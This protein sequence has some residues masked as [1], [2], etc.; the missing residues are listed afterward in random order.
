MKGMSNE[1]EDQ[2]LQ[3]WNNLCDTKFKAVYSSGVAKRTAHLGTL[4]SMFLALGT[5]GTVASWPLWQAYPIYWAVVLGVIQILQIIKPYIPY[6]GTEKQYLDTSY[7]FERLFLDFELLWKQFERGA[8]Q[9]DET[10][11]RF[12]QLRERG[13]DIESEYSLIIPEWNRL[14]ERANQKK[15]SF[16]HLNYPSI[17]ALTDGCLSESIEDPASA[18]LVKE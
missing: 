5:A 2:R 7:K 9:R 4:Y 10:E 15:E 18:K 12:K 16:M 13:L 11:L 6:I 3:I 1:N 17:V 8:I 14:M